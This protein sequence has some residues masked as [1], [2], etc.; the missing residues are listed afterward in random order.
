MNTAS[1]VLRKISPRRTSLRRAG[2]AVAASGALAMTAAL[3]LA[4]P[5]GA[6]T[7]HGGGYQFR[8]VDN[9]KDLTF[10]QLLGVNNEGVIAGYFG[11]GAQG[12]PNKGYQLLPWGHGYFASENFPLRHHH[13]QRRERRRRPGRVLRGRRGQH[14]WHD[15]DAAR[16]TSIFP[17]GGPAGPPRLACV[18]G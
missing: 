15:R 17:P 16:L 1:R 9:A 3:T 7:L 8:T 14:R 2:V 5:A 6:S 12:H 10:N 4:G 18:R 13:H 11:S